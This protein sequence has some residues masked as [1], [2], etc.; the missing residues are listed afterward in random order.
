MATNIL[1]IG[2]GIAN[3]IG[4]NKIKMGGIKP[5]ASYRCYDK[6]NDDADRNVLT[7][8]TG[9]GHDIQLYNFA[10]AESS[11][12]GKYGT[13][14]NNFATYTNRGELNVKH[15]RVIITSVKSSNSN[16]IETT[17]DINI[18]KF[19]INVIGMPID[20]DIRLIYSYFEE[21]GTPKYFVISSDGIYE[22]PATYKKYTGFKINQL[23]ESCN[24]TIEQIPD[25][26]G[27]LV[28]DGVDDYGL[29][30]NF[31]ILTK[32]KGYTVCAI[33]KWI[34]ETN[35]WFIDLSTRSAY[36]TTFNFEFSPSNNS[37][38]YKSFGGTTVKVTNTS[39]FSYMTSVK[40]NGVSI[41]PGYRNASNLLTVFSNNNRNSYSNIA[42][43]ALEIYD[44]DLTDEEIAKVKERMIAE[45]EAKTG[46]KYEEETA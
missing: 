2:I 7:D 32:E 11:G 38:N 36:D 29:C 17:A 13:D 4:F 22:L 28:S 1:G 35:A 6:T 34:N 45:Y 41:V 30:E 9:N 19:K 31:P 8:L 5:I 16:F 43:Y 12:Y 39:L 44:R 25:Y 20:T 42:F 33:R 10:F 24:I 26:Q 46:N 23:L 21:D 37:Y 18:D 3:A 15:D 40:A 27:A 14:F